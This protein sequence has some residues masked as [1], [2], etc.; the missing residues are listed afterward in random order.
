M[1]NQFPSITILTAEDDPDDQV[2]VRDAFLESGQENTLLFVQDGN[3][4]LQYLRRQGSYAEPG[5]APRPDLILLD[6]NMPNMDGSPVAGG[7][8][9]RP[10][11]ASHSGGGA[12][13]F[14]IG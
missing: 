1:T 7:D 6:L 5:E 3:D 8:Q 13:G 4:L 11:P 10:E 12:D 9:S 14:E 2:L